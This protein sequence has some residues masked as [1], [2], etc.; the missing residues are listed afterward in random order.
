MSF[1]AFQRKF[2]AF[3]CWVIE[4]EAF[5]KDIKNGIVRMEQMC[6]I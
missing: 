6:Q 3:L 2:D 4:K 1:D 5:K